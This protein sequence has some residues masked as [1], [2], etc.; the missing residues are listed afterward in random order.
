MAPIGAAL[1]TLK[2]QVAAVRDGDKWHRTVQTP[3]PGTAVTVPLE[4]IE[5]NGLAALLVRVKGQI[6]SLLT[7]EVEGDFI[8]AVRTIINPDKLA[9][10]NLPPTSGQEWRL[11]S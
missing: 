8:R 7:L 11:I 10:L 9:H 1:P 2:S 5:A 6:A 4:V 3:S